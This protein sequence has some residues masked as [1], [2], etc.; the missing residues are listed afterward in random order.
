[1]A[2]RRFSWR[3]GIP[4]SVVTS[5][6]PAGIASDAQACT[7]ISIEEVSNTQSEDRNELDALAD[8]LGLPLTR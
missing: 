5:Y 2:Y 6:A 1:M 8:S 4:I 7:P 3:C